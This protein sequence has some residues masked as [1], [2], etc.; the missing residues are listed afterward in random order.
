MKKIVAIVAVIVLAL[1]LLPAYA[2]VTA[3]VAEDNLWLRDKNGKVIDQT[4][5]RTI[6]EKYVNIASEDTYIP[7]NPYDR[8][9]VYAELPP[10]DM[11]VENVEAQ[12]G[13]ITPGN[14][15]KY[16]DAKD[17]EAQLEADRKTEYE[18]RRTEY[19]KV[20]SEIPS[21]ILAA[22]SIHENGVTGS[23]KPAELSDFEPIIL[24][25]G[26]FGDFEDAKAIIAEAE[27]RIVTE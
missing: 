9:K 19:L 1:M 13:E 21:T 22:L 5:A 16:L 3:K 4:T 15:K 26:Q 14:I 20:L 25:M 11:V 23:Y 18:K 12:Y 8:T 17:A 2:A 7:D 6:A 24:K 10:Y 27:E